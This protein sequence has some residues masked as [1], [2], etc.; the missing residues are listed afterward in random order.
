MFLDDLRDK[1]IEKHYSYKTEQAYV[2][3][4]KRFI[5]FN[6]KRHPREMGKVELE[7]FLTSLAKNGLGAKSQNQAYSAIKFMYLEL[8][9]KDL[10]NLGSLRAKE[11]QRIPAVLSRTDT[12]RVLDAVREHPYN[13]IARTLYGGGLRLGECLHLRVKDIDFGRYVIIVHNGKGDKDRTTTLPHSLIKPLMDQLGEARNYWNI[14]RHRNMPG[15]QIPNSLDVKYPGIGKEFGWFWVFP[16]PEYS[17]DPRSRIRRRHHIHESGVQRAVRD[18]AKSIDLLVRVSPHTFRHC[19]ATHLLEAGYD[20]RT[21]QEL[22]GHKD[23]KTTMLYTHV[24]RPGGEF[25]VVSP[26]D[27]V[28][29][30]DTI[31]Q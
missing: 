6:G 2:Q 7:S 23:V 26:L 15:V 13:L 9:G 1:L 11:T 28:H 27:S 4:V 16:A 3:W 24:I 12:L 14:D 21:V 31:R 22:L 18:A 25:G 29:T 30:E 10:G 5:L 17:I 19:F 20:I 8:L